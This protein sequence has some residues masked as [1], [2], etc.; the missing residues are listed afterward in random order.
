MNLS[1]EQR[2]RLNELLSDSSLEL[3]PHRRTVSKHGSNYA[4]LKQNL[5]QRNPNVSDELR[6][7]L[8]IQ[9]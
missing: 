9:C 4:W 2:Q 1:Q 8:C 7:L 3:P 5:T 6:S